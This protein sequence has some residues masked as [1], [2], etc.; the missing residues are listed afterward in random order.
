L[1]VVLVY[2]NPF[3]RNPL[4]KSVLVPVDS[5]A[6]WR[7]AVSCPDV[8]S[9]RRQAPAELSLLLSMAPAE[10]RRWTSTPV[11]AATMTSRDHLAT[12]VDGRRR[13]CR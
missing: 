11:S 7:D 5:R 12:D 13:R 1:Q 6:S 4:L 10:L 2:L 3:R 8:K 9:R